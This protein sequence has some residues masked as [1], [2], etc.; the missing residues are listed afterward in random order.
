MRFDKR[1]DLGF[2][3]A[4]FA[5]MIVTL[6][7]TA[8]IGIMAITVADDTDEQAIMIDRRIFEKLSVED[9]II[10]GDIENDIVSA[11]E[12]YGYGGIGIRCSVP[13]DL[14]LDDVS[15]YIGELNGDIISEK[16]IVLLSSNDGRA[17]PAIVEM[18]I[19]T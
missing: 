11:A 1:G 13:G 3:E 6:S 8:F 12:R 17:I 10:I 19:C 18:M 2:P 15:F 14:G 9:G 16:C 7:L 5:V 4:I